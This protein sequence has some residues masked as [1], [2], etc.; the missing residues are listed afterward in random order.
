MPSISGGTSTLTD[1]S[2]SSSNM[3]YTDSNAGNN[4]GAGGFGGRGARA[5][6]GFGGGRGGNFRNGQ[7]PEDMPEP[8][9]GFNGK[10]PNKLR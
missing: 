7:L 5:A 6:G 10:R 3:V 4:F 8:P 9:E 2:T 1:I